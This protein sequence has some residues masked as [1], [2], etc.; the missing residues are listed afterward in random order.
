MFISTVSQSPAT[1]LE[2]ITSLQSESQ[3]EDLKAQTI[4]KPTDNKGKGLI[5]VI[6]TTYTQPRKPEYQLEV[7]ADEAGASHCV[8]LT[9]ELPQVCSMSDC[10]LRISKVSALLAST[11]RT[12]CNV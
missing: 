6:S 12:H 2:Q 3:N 5:Q 11:V 8:K 7:K 10:Q 4:C 9:V 1:L